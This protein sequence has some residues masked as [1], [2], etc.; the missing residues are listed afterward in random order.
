MPR[1]LAESSDI[2]CLAFTKD[3]RRC[4][5]QRDDGQQTCEYHKEYF[6]KW[7]ETH[8][9]FHHA[10]SSKRQMEEYRFQ[11]CNHHVTIPESYIAT[12]TI[13]YQAY[14]EFLVKETGCSSLVNHR[15]FKYGID[16]L[17]W[18]IFI[19]TNLARTK[20]LFNSL[21]HFFTDVESILFCFRLFWKEMVETFRFYKADDEMYQKRFQQVFY[22]PVWRP[23]LFNKELWYTIQTVWEENQRR[24]IEQGILMNRAL[25]LKEQWSRERFQDML[26]TMTAFHQKKMK[27]RIQPFKE[28]LIAAAWH[29]KRVERWLEMGG[30]ELLDAL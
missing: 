26:Y 4:R 2:Q 11:I 15:C 21:A 12:L 13:H 28:E 16:T 7:L 25:E 19:E 9:G 18:A 22:S 27:G 8:K 20:R 29:P 17:S 3:H 10:I 30:F 1:Y 6:L 5:L 24:E 23:I 14:Y